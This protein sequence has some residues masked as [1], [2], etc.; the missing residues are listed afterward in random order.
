MSEPG[1]VI[2]ADDRDRSLRTVG[3]ISY[4]LHTVVAIGAVISGV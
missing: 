4:L 2:V 1:S 3:N